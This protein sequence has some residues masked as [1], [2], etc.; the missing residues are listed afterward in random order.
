MG[1]QLNMLGVCEGGCVLRCTCNVS[2]MSAVFMSSPLHC[3]FQSRRW[4]VS[5]SSRCIMLAV[6]TMRRLQI[7]PERL[8]AS[9]LAVYDC[10]LKQ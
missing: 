9:G 7:G 3:T 1:N 4:I 10:T 2:C 5:W 8:M 6:I